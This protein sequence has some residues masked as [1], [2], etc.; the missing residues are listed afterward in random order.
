MLAYTCK[1]YSGREYA[2]NTNS[3]I[4]LYD[5]ENKK[6]TNLTNGMVGYDQESGILSGGKSTGMGKPGGEW[7]EADRHRLFLYDF[8]T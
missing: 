5:V 2:L 7:N 4:Y 8:A 1:K 6:T 3:D